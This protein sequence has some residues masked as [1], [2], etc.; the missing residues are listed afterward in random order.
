MELQRS[1]YESARMSH[2][3]PKKQMEGSNYKDKCSQQA[4]DMGGMSNCGKEK[5]SLQEKNRGE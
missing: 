2:R 4:D 3:S 1:T 5:T